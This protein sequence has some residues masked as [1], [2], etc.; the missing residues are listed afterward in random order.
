MFKAVFF[1]RRFSFYKPKSLVLETIL[2]F[3]WLTLSA[4]SGSSMLSAMEGDLIWLSHTFPQ[5]HCVEETVGLAMTQL[6]QKYSNWL[7]II[8]SIHFS[9]FR[10]VWQPFLVSKTALFKSVLDN[11][12]LGVATSAQKHHALLIWQYNF[13]H[14]CI[15]PYGIRS[16]TIINSPQHR[17]VFQVLRCLILR[18]WG[19]DCGGSWVLLNS[20]GF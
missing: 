4:L 6:H 19:L 2:P 9:G 10:E 3:S 8:K 13:N 20:H 15:L 1:V 18:L 5:S 11:F 12:K 16:V 7:T 17:N 14:L